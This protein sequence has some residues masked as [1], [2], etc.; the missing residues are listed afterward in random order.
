METGRYNF[1]EKIRT[2]QSWKDPLESGASRHGRCW[3]STAILVALS[4]GS[5]TAGFSLEMIMNIWPF[6]SQQYARW[7]HGHLVK[8]PDLAHPTAECRH[9]IIASKGCGWSMEGANT[10]HHFTECAK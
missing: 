9:V 10:A 2:V 4:A 8:T 3:L 6:G 5:Q 1:G 7:D